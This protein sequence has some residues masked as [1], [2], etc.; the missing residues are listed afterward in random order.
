MIY[1]INFVLNTINL[2]KSSVTQKLGNS[3][4]SLSPKLTTLGGSRRQYSTLS[5]SSNIY[6]M[7]NQKPIEFDSL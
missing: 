4:S 5:K 6:E 2:S 3:N 7:Y 1:K